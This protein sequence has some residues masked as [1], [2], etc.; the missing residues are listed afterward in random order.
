MQNK[1][2][3]IPFAMKTRKGYDTEI[4]NNKRCYYKIVRENKKSKQVYLWLK[5]HT[6]QYPDPLFVRMLQETLHVKQF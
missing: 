5:R 2:E 1:K 6:R 3:F 4:F